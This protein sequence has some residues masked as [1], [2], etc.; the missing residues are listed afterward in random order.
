MYDRFVT[1]M[2]LQCASA[3]ALFQAVGQCG[4]PC[5]GCDVL[6]AVEVP[7][8]IRHC[9]PTKL[10]GVTQRHSIFLGWR[11]LS[12]YSFV[13]LQPGWMP[14][15]APMHTC[16]Q[17]Q[18]WRALLRQDCKQD[19]EHPDI[20]NHHVHRT[21]SRS[22]GHMYPFICVRSQPSI[23]QSRALSCQPCPRRMP[24]A[25]RCLS[26]RKKSFNVCHAHV[27][28]CECIFAEMHLPLPW[29]SFHGVWPLL[30]TASLQ[31]LLAALH[32]KVDGSICS[33]CMTLVADD[34]MT[35]KIR[36]AGR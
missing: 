10:C 24:K 16:G 25:G 31:S 35:E 20:Q 7:A 4:T 5:V 12:A 28:L 3:V 19:F 15:Q 17:T 22:S 30:S 23:V 1:W 2:E 27:R 14:P 33:L 36:Q 8:R 26:A 9:E 18:R 13:R 29:V 6:V 32:Q 34:S 21:P 11:N